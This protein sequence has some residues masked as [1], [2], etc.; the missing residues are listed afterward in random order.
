MQLYYNK[1]NYVFEG[2]AFNV[3]FIIDSLIMNNVT[4]QTLKRTTLIFKKQF[5]YFNRIFK[6][7]KNADS[8]KT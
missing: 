1:K 4:K 5:S 6:N 3:L 7:I 2:G 8:I